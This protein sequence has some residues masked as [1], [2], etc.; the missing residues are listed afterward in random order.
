MEREGDGEK[1]RKSIAEYRALLDQVNTKV[2]EK[3]YSEEVLALTSRLLK[4]NPEYYTI[5]NYRRLI[6]LNHFARDVTTTL[7]HDSTPLTLSK[8]TNDIIVGDLQFIVP[9]LIQYPKCYWI[10]NYRLWLLEEAEKQVDKGTTVRLWKDELALVGKMLDRDERNFHGW[11][12]RR[13]IVSQLER[14]AE[15]EQKTMAEQEF[16]YTSKMMRAALQNFSALHYRLKLIPKLLDER[17]ADGAARRKMLDEELESMQEALID[18]FNQSAW[19][20]HQYLMSTLSEDCPRDAAIVLDLSRDDRIHYYEQEVERIKEMLEDFDDCK[21]IYE[22]LV[23]YS[24]EYHQ[25]TDIKPK[26]D[27]QFWLDELQRLDPMRSGRWKDLR[28]A[29][30]L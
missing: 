9:L 19:F 30:K 20:Y 22:A 13:N 21:W 10:W 24:I 26:N 2:E 6:L 7:E 5:W 27:L 29:L 8:S 15:P 16:A 17:Q 11:G 14:L 25:L 12:Y 18:P 1:E 23:Q 4:K 28:E 3:Q